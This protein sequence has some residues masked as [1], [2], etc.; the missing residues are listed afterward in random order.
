MDDK[1]NEGFTNPKKSAK[2]KVLKAYLM[3]EK[4]IIK[5]DNYDNQ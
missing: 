3:L 5:I 1:Q 2:D 4:M